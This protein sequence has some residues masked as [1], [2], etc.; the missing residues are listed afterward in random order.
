MRVGMACPTH[1]A[2]HPRPVPGPAADPN[3]GGCDA[4]QACHVY[5][6]VVCS[7]DP[8]IVQSDERFEKRHPEGTRR[9]DVLDFVMYNQYTKVV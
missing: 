4:G 9:L 5:T 8:R 2:P 7:D 1:A 3:V 6:H